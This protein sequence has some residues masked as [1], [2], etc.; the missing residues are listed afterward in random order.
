MDFT[1]DV[2]INVLEDWES[3]HFFKKPTLPQPFWGAGNVLCL[4]LGAGDMEKFRVPSGI[5]WHTCDLCLFLY[6]CYTSI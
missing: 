4:D 1:L 5:R 2:G 6:A 3:K